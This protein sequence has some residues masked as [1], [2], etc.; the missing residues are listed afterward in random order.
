MSTYLFIANFT[1][2]GARGVLAE[3]GKARRAV[4]EKLFASLGGTM[5]SFYF[6]FGSDD[7]FIIGKLPGNAEAAAAA[8]T[9]S[10]TGAVHTRTIV[11]LTPEELD[12]ASKLSPSYRA[13][14]A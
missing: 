10:S 9:T 6:A 13:P 3:G 5:E 11:L 12:A 2:E 4:I 7:V 14:G 1:A 8:L